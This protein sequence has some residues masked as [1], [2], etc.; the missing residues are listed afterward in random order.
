MSISTDYT[1]NGDEHRMVFLPLRLANKDKATSGE[2]V[3]DVDNGVVY[4][5][6]SDNALHSLAVDVNT[7]LQTIEDAGLVD[8]AL[9]YVNNS[10]VYT[11]YMK[12][13]KVKLDE[14]LKLNKNI[15]YWAARGTTSD[16]TIQYITGTL[17]SGAVSNSLI[18]VTHDTSDSTIVYN[19]TALEGP[20][21]TPSEI[22]DGGL[23]Y[24]DFFDSNRVVVSTVPAQIRKVSSLDFSLS[25]DANII[26]L[27]ITTNQDT[28]TTVDGV[29]VRSAF[30]YQ[31][32]STE[33]LNVY[34]TAVYANG[35][36]RYLNS[37]IA[38]SRLAI[39]YPTTTVGG[40]TNLSSTVGDSFNITAKY[41][42]NEKA[43]ASGNSSYS[44]TYYESISSSITVNV[45]EDVYTGVRYFVPVPII[46]Y[47]TTNGVSQYV[48][49]MKYFAIYTSGSYEDISSNTRLSISNFTSTSFGVDQPIT[50]HLGLGHSDATYY[51][52]I[53]DIILT[54][55]HYGK[56]DLIKLSSAAASWQDRT[57]AQVAALF[58][59]TST[60]NSIRMGFAGITSSS[61]SI[62][63]YATTAAFAAIGEGKLLSTDTVNTQPTHFRVRSVINSTHMYTVDMISVEDYYDFVITEDSDTSYSLSGAV[64]SGNNSIPYP[65]LIEFYYYNS[66]AKTYTLLSLVPAISYAYVFASGE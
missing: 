21:H 11:L 19:G 9:A 8:S 12:D 66:I 55:T 36:T 2:L 10:Q 16:G 59:T 18:D 43:D 35:D 53:F 60:S 4:T 3:V 39:T 20:L 31:G 6:G 15:Y 28:T 5:K 54:S 50:A 45:I 7:K 38:S 25:P 44:D 29:V 56:W 37:Y 42:T 22:V 57:I 41:Y 49:T 65:V 40:K 52:E 63:K 61:D 1:S 13:S 62:T 47:I 26:S 14:M 24:I 46:H 64:G 48:A 27:Q 33:S 30:I 32:Q 58:D 34:V 51:E 17:V 23:Y